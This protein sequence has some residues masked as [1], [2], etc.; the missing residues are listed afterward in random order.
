[1]NKTLLTKFLIL[2]AAAALLGVCIYAAFSDYEG[3][4]RKI[5]E[6]GR[7]AEVAFVPAEIDVVDFG[8]ASEPSPPPAVMPDGA[9]DIFVDGRAA[10][11][12]S[13]RP[14]AE[15]LLKKYLN[16]CATAPEG[17]HFLSA[18]YDCD[19]RI[20]PATGTA[21]YYDFDTAFNLLF[22]EPRLVPVTVKT[23]RRTFSTGA[24]T[25]TAGTSSALYKGCRRIAQLGAGALTVTY[26]ELTYIGDEPVNTGTPRTEVAVEARA[27]IVENGS[28]RDKN[29]EKDAGKK[30]KDAGNLKL[31]YP[32]RGSTVSYF[33]VD[34]G[35]MCA[36]I[37]IE[38]KAGTKVSAPGEGVV[39]YCGERGEYGFV[40]DI[41]HGDGFVSR[42]T[43]LADVT[44]E[45]NQRVFAGDAV[46]KLAE[47]ERSGKK[48]RLH[49][50][51]LVD[52]V[53]YNPLYYLE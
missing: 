52:G 40:V 28:L 2:A 1:M 46:G 50:E 26:T 8:E 47:S 10:V 35:S 22:S 9:V 41:D 18:S 27:M 49:Y 5:A 6:D 43:H 39:I 48:P 34:G 29:S 24:V 45:L 42:L 17:E 12:V 32:M 3:G 21:P 25:P 11:A 31:S 4:R 20:V 44:L 15:A 19:I 14:E 30:G 33:G 23:L 36:G 7:P 38:N 51:L 13:G 53:P 37:E 16:I